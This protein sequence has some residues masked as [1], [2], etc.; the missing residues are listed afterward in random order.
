MNGRATI[1]WADG[2][3]SQA[4]FKF[5]SRPT[6]MGLCKLHLTTAL[7]KI[8]ELALMQ[9]AYLR[10]EDGRLLKIF[11]TDHSNDRADCLANL[12]SPVRKPTV[13]L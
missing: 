11:V 12:I 4:S 6:V 1:M 2:T 3:T 13:S 10:C 5:L 7:E 9:S 8:A